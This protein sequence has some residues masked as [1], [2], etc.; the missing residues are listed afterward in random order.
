MRTAQINTDVLNTLKLHIGMA[1]TSDESEDTSL[2]LQIRIAEIDAEF[3]AMLKSISSDSVDAFDENKAK[4]LMKEKSNLQQQLSQ[5]ANTKQKRE[6]AQSR[7]D[8]I[9]TILDGLKNHPMQY[10]DRIVR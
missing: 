6:N 2:A 5:I 1:L 10:D 3:A 4:D 9:Y 7:L 8:D